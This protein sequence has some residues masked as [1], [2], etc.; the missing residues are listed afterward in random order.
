[1]RKVLEERLDLRLQLFVT[2]FRTLSG[3]LE[4]VRRVFG[5]RCGIISPPDQRGQTE[6][7]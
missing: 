2:V 6:L 7:A 1:M 4:D 3:E 5:H